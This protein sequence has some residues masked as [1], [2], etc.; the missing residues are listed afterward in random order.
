VRCP[1]SGNTCC[2][3]GDVCFNDTLGNPQCCPAGLQTCTGPQGT[4]CCGESQTCDA[5]TGDC[6]NA[7][8]EPCGKAGCCKK[9]ACNHDANAPMCCPQVGVP[10]SPCGGLGNRCC[11]HSSNPCPTAGAGAGC[12]AD[13]TCVACPPP[14]Q[15][16]SYFETDTAYGKNCF[17]QDADFT[18][19]GPCDPG[20]THADCTAVPTNSGGGNF[21]CTAQLANPQ[22]PNDCTCTA[23]FHTPGDCFK[24]ISCHITIREQANVTKPTGCP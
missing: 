3:T 19:G 8:E 13:G 1:V 16:R 9:G 24:F 14:P 7:D 12:S 23:H 4:K 11:L 6:C 15:P 21:T 18:Y 17:P 5:T 22:F 2:N 10:C 20:F